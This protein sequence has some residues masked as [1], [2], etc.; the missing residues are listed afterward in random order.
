MSSI[1]VARAADARAVQMLLYG[2]I[3]LGFFGVLFVRAWLISELP[4][5]VDETWTGVIAGQNTWASFWRA[6]WLD[7]NAPLYYAFMALWTDLFGLS[8]V[9]LRTPS[10][11]FVVAAAMVPAIWKTPGLSR[12]A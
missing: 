10:L 11:I 3:A 1:P 4:L 6:A 7:C 2:L 12:E 8:N 9:A 5:W